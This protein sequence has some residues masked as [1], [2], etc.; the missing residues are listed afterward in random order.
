MD[1]NELQKSAVAGDKKAEQELFRLL[2]ARFRFFAKQDMWNAEDSEEAVQDALTIVF[3]KYRDIDFKTSF[4]SWAHKVLQ[5]TI[6][7]YNS[8]RARRN[9]TMTGSDGAEGKE[10]VFVSDPLFE[11]KLLDCLRKVS[12]RNSHFARALN[13]CYQGYPANDI[14][15]RLKLTKGN[16]YSVLSRARSMLDLCLKKGGL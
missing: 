14:C 11:G 13:L 9:E 12:R 10:M 4:I 7:N 6:W 2:T 8:K 1:I 15:L 3:G 16:F 5:N